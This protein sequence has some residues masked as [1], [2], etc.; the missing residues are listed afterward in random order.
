M[1]DVNVESLEMKL[2]L[3]DTLVERA[4]RHGNMIWP[5]DIREILDADE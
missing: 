3:I 2:S 5:D 1:I 4:E